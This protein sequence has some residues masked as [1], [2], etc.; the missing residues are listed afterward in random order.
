MIRNSEKIIIF[1]NKDEDEEEE[2]LVD[3]EL[4]RRDEMVHLRA[5]LIPQTVLLLHSVLHNTGRNI[6]HS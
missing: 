1:L 4:R 2:L 3:E 5:E 6:L